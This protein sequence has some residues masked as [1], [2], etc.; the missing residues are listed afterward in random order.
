MNTFSTNQ[1][2]G[3]NY[4][5]P[6]HP[7]TVHPQQIF[8]MQNPGGDPTTLCR[9]CGR[10]TQGIANKTLGIVGAMT[11]LA[12]ILTVPFV[13]CIPCCCDNCKDI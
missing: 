8:V 3:G 4:S 6:V 11:V 13:S 7:Q 12:L 5:Q 9:N 10:N 1:Y 2:P